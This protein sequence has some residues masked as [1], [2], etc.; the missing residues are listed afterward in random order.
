[1]PLPRSVVVSFSDLA[2][3][4]PVGILGAVYV[5]VGRSCPQDAQEAREVACC[6]TLLGDCADIVPSDLPSHRAAPFRTVGFS[7]ATAQERDDGTVHA[8]LS[9]VDVRRRGRSRQVPEGQLILQRLSARTHP[10]AERSRGTGKY[11]RYLFESRQGRSKLIGVGPGPY[12]CD[13]E[14]H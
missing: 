4:F 6:Q 2:P 5:H 11:G 7:V 12:S 1:M 3:N 8:P 13:A 9:E 10:R 14:A